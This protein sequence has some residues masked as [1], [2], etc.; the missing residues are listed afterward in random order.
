MMKCLIMLDDMVDMFINVM[1][2]YH[3]LNISQLNNGNC[4][5][6]IHS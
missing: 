1:V 2:M 4:A 6:F 5:K 3:K